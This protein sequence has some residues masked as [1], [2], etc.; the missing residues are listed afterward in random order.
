M[1]FIIFYL[2]EKRIPLACKKLCGVQ[3]SY[4]QNIQLS[5]I[6]YTVKTI[7]YIRN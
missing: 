2:Q 3:L 7:D 1:D 6:N 4:M 5:A